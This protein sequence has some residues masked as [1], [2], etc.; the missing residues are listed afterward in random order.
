M[1]TASLNIRKCFLT[2]FVCLPAYL[3]VCICAWA[4]P[5]LVLAWL[6]GIYSYLAAQ[7]QEPLGLTKIKLHRYIFRKIMLSMLRAHIQNV[8]FLNILIKF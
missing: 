1:F 2:T 3:S 8:T 6:N 7:K 5:S 4:C